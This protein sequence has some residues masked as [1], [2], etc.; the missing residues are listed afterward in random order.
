MTSNL[1]DNKHGLLSLIKLSIPFTGEVLNLGVILQDTETNE[2]RMKIIE[3]FGK[4]EKCFQIPDIEN[5]QYAI[6][7]LQKRQISRETIYSGEISSSLVVTE[8]SKY[9]ITARNIEEELS[10]A[11]FA[12]VSLAK[13]LSSPSGYEPEELKLAI[14]PNDFKTRLIP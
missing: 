13:E 12:K 14:I 8:P 3:D 7:I 5:I 11:F 2:I 10:N 4:L 6:E 9:I 1:S